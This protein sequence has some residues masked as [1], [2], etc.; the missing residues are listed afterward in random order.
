MTK[1]TTKRRYTK[2]I[3]L[4]RFL[5]KIQWNVFTGCLNWIGAKNDSGYGLFYHERLIRAHRWAYEQVYGPIPKELELDHL[6]RNRACVNWQHLESVTRSVNMLRSPLN[7]QHSRIMG[8]SKRKHNLPEGVY[9][10][11]NKYQA[12]K[13][14]NGQ[15]FHLG[16]FDSPEAAHNAYVIFIENCNGR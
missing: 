14:H 13:R 1:G 7:K 11:R 12:V 6:C 9:L 8:L 3:P 2:Q 5:S 4:D 16:T 10:M 15:K